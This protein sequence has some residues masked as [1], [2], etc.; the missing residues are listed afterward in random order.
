MGLTFDTGALIGLERRRHAMRA[1][2]ATAIAHRVPITVSAI[3]IAEWWRAGLREKERGAILRSLRV[4]PVTDYVARLAGVAVGLV[5]G[6]GAVDAVV[7]ASAS[8]RGDTVYTSDPRD[9]AR[10]QASVPQF[11]NVRVLVV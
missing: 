6:A 10:L 4:E 2:Y 11:A 3:V 1:V 9:L 7:M 8:L 5:R